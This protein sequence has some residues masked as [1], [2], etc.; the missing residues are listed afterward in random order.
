MHRDVLYNVDV[1][2]AI[3]DVDEATKNY[4]KAEKKVME[5]MLQKLNRMSSHD[6]LQS[7][8]TD[9]SDL[10]VQGQLEVALD[11]CRVVYL[12]E[13]LNDG[14]EAALDRG[15][16]HCGCT[17]LKPALPFLTDLSKPVP[18]A[19]AHHAPRPIDCLS[20]AVL[21]VDNGKHADRDKG[22]DG[23]AWYS[24]IEMR[25]ALEKK[26]CEH[27]RIPGVQIVVQGSYGTLKTIESALSHKLQVVLIHDSGG[28]ANVLA[29][30]VGPLLDEAPN[31]PR[32]E[33]KRKHRVEERIEEY[34]K[35]NAK[36]PELAQMQ[37]E[38]RKTANGT[39]VEEMWKTI[40]EICMELENISTVSLARR[41]N[42]LSSHI[43][44]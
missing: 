38:Y 10:E 44:Y 1:R 32:E 29:E 14:Y 30:L 39:Q 41:D 37:R 12:K 23:K 24:E 26:I 42:S 36:A 40:L 11:K 43:L 22:K 33:M 9:E 31:L 18:L 19:T 5:R 8:A 6:L 3:D 25:T 20:S 17:G 21:L 34:K 4:E 27:Y 2:N 28:A 35:Q 16:T 15:H 13:K 7:K